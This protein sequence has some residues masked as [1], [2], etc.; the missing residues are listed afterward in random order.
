MSSICEPKIFT[1]F[2]ISKN[3][4]EQIDERAKALGISRSEYVRSLVIKKL[5]DGKND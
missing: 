1:G 2:L 4:V 5:N 3:L